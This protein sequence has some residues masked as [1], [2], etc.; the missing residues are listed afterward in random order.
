MRIL[1]YTSLYPDA[2]HP[3]HGI[4]V[5]ELAKALK[6][7][8]R[9][10]VVVPVNGL[11]RPPNLLNLGL[12]HQGPNHGATER[13]HD[14]GVRHC[15]F[16]TIPK[17]FKWLDSRLMAFFSLQAFRRGLAFRP[18]LIHAHYAYP[19]G[20]AAAILAG[21]A[22][23]PLV[24]TC[25][26]S[27]INMLAKDPARG[28]LIAR[29]LGQAAAVVAVSRDLASKIAGLGVPPE[30]IVHIP[31]GVDLSRFPLGDKLEARR[32]LNMTEDRPLLVA[33]G[34][35]EPVKGYDRLLRAL[36]L[37][38]GVRLVLAGDGSQRLALTFLAHHLGIDNRVH[39]A[40]TVPHAQLA[41]YF[42]AADLLVISS[43]SEGWPTII[44][45][46]LA[47]GT[48]VV[49]TSVGGIP[50]ALADSALGLLLPSGEPEALAQGIRQALSATWDGPALRRAAAEHDWNAVV[51]RHL[52]LYAHLLDHPTMRPLPITPREVPCHEHAH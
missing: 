9:V 48:P 34:R 47:C 45:E 37:L 36:A 15:R 11:R 2:Q 38:P 17:V 29:A 24:V 19:D 52:D 25:H 23:L 8:A 7:E 5:Q 42:Q 12:N 13:P 10:E 49:A 4:F 18:D 46:A 16:Y 30:Q 44:H 21:R 22:G 35:L 14:D 33:A 50:E 27:D 32:T 31:N 28:A 51:A 20:A 39:F 43:H 41:P 3:T 1:L 6:R 26:G 40:G